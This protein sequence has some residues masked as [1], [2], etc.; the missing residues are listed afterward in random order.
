VDGEDVFGVLTLVHSEAGRFREDDLVLLGA[1]A[2]NAAMLGGKTL[3]VNRKV[4]T[5]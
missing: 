1:I 5:P 3:R 2:V 4:S